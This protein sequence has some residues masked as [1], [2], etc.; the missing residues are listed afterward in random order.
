M[1]TTRDGRNYNAAASVRPSYEE[2]AAENR[3]LQA[4]VQELL[5]LIEKLRRETK[6]QAAPFRKQ[7]EPAAEPKKPGRKSGR[8]HGP[9]AHRARRRGLTRPTMCRCRNN[10]SIAVAPT[11]RKPTSRRNIKPKFHAPSSIASSRCMSACANSAARRWKAA[12][13]CRSTRP[14]ERRPVSWGK[15]P[16]GT[17]DHEQATRP[18]ARQERETA[19]DVFRGADHL[20]AGHQCPIIARTA[21]RCEPAYEQLRNDVR[22]S[23]QSCPTRPAGAWAAGRPGCMHSW[24][25][26]KRVM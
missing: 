25:N 6:R 15:R 1:D 4:R 20:C 10:V 9:H 14:A 17:G 3:R 19:G 16:C 2:L 23:P 22:G 5:L 18:V 8:R 12:M 24:A 11:C 13:H 26:G 21:E 7:D